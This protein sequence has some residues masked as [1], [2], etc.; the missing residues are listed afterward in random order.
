[1]EIEF[2]RNNSEFVD[3]KINGLA[4]TVYEGV[5]DK[6]PDLNKLKSVHNGRIFEISVQNIKKREDHIAIIFKGFIKILR[7]GDYCFYA[8]ANDGC[9]LSINKKVVVDNAG[10]GGKKE[11]QNLI[12]LTAGKHPI[13]ILYFENTGSE[14]IDV[15]YEGPALKK[16]TIPASFLY[17][18]K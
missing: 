12:R 17:L 14:S 18:N 1:M 6:R 8:N 4:Y 15:M 7:D 16:Q 13:K 9:V 10:Y 2:I 3:P 5:W 11:K